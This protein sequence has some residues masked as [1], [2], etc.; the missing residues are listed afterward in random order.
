MY[1]KS[2]KAILYSHLDQLERERHRAK[3]LRS[4][5]NKN[6]NLTSIASIFFLFSIVLDSNQKLVQFDSFACNKL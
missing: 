5:S 3:Q 4:N 2:Q 1:Y 6:Q